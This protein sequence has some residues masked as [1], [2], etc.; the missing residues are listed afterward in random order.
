[1]SDSISEAVAREALAAAGSPAADPSRYAARP[2][3]EGW[4]FSWSSAEPVPLGSSP[5]VVS[6]SQLVRR[7]GIGERAEDVLADLTKG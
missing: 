5:W 2:L 3:G 4:A 7:V 6:N 1:M